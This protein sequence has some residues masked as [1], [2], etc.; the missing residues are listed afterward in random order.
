LIG[1][2]FRKTNSIR[3]KR[4]LVIL[5]TPAI[6]NDDQGGDYGYGYEPSTQAA[7]KLIYQP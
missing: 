4:E 2:F 5:V 6:V 7:K 3:E 1:Q